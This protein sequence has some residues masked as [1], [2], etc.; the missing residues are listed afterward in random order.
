MLCTCPVLYCLG[1][2]EDEYYGSCIVSDWY[3][4]VDHVRGAFGGFSVVVMLAVFSQA[5]LRLAALRN[6][7]FCLEQMLIYHVHCTVKA[8]KALETTQTSCFRIPTYLVNL[9]EYVSVVQMIILI[10]MLFSQLLRPG[11][12]LA[13]RTL[14]NYAFCMRQVLIYPVHCS[15]K[16]HSACEVT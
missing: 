15:V 11:V 8:L 13:R 9:Q 2:W 1:A 10:W 14:R 6:F 12:P 7:T 4:G 5:E 16:A 3:P